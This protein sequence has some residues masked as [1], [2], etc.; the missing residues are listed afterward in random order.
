[1]HQQIASLPLSLEP[2]RPLI[3]VEKV[4]YVYPDGRRALEDID[5]S[6]QEGDRIALVGQNG[7]GKTTLAKVLNGLYTPRRGRV[8]YAGGLLEGDHL[9]RARTEIGLFFQDPDD[10]LFCNTVYE[11]V[12][13]GP[14]NQGWDPQE[15]DRRVREAVEHV[16]LEAFLYKP[17]HHLSYGQRKR[18][19]F[20]AVLAMKPRVL[21]LDEPTANLDPRQEAVFV[22]LLKK[23]QGTLIVISHDLLF[24]YG[25]CSRAVVLEHGRI[26]HDYTLDALVA[27]RPSLREH[28]LDFSFRFSCCGIHEPGRIEP[29]ADSGN[30]Q[31]SGGPEGRSSRGAEVFPLIQLKDFAYRYPDGTWGVR[32]IDLSVHAGEK[33][34]LVGENGAGKST[35][36]ACLQGLRLGRGTYRFDGKAVD[37]KRRKRLWRH[38]GMVFQDSSDQLFCPS[39]REEVAFGPRQMGLAAAEVDRRT[40]EALA[41]VGLEGFEDRAPHRLSGGERKRLAIAAVLGMHPRVLILDEPTSG[42]DP[43]SEERLLEILR[44]LRVTLVVISHDV[45]FLS[46]LCERTVVMHGG[47]IIR[48]GPMDAFLNDEHLDSLNG[49]AYT[50][51]SECRRRILRLQESAFPAAG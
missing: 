49:L 18:A 11:D 17:A 25:L 31:E 47:R 9:L 39:C 1:M 45:H 2:G 28:G 8:C 48:D 44:E 4:S 36:A 22:E 10:H 12:A 33:L 46:L 27:H 29:S 42:L 35:L 32:C 50:Y 20:A 3:A 5:L 21:I 7:S 43:R 26:H 14:L 41:R 15:V 40:R 51:K 19:A 38:I 24:L 6:V 30:A 37:E 23:F 16:G 13:F 34:A